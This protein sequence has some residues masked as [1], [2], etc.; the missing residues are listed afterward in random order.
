MRKIMS[1]A[2]AMLVAAACA[3]ASIIGSDSFSYADGSL[4][5]KSGGTGWTP[6][7]GSPTQW[8]KAF[9]NSAAV[10]AGSVSTF[11]GGSYREY[12]A[13]IQATGAVYFG[14]D[15]TL[16]S[17]AV[18]SQR[19][20]GVSSYDFG[21]ER[22]KFGK[23]WSATTFGLDGHG[24][25]ATSIPIVAGQTYRIV[26]SIQWDTGGGQGRLKMWVNPDA[27]DFDT[28]LGNGVLTTADLVVNYGSTGNWNNGVRLASGGSNDNAPA[29]Y[30]NLIVAT[31]FAEAA[32]VPEPGALASLALM[33]GLLRRRR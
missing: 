18:V 26:G 2:A 23:T 30:D 12:G 3:Q 14:V 7:G 22:I 1:A 32:A 33:A 11:N 15:M 27:A 24:A 6:G 21:N 25:H 8:N 10:T 19:Y 31:T 20:A 28:V 17:N 5:G 9:G 16:S 13:A 4:D 29:T